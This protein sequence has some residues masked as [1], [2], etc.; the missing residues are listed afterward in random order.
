MSDKEIHFCSNFQINA[1][2]HQIRV[3]NEALFKGDYDL[4]E[5]IDEISINNCLTNQFV[6][7]LPL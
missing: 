5:L 6:L 2:K 4:F 1:T 3:T 7:R